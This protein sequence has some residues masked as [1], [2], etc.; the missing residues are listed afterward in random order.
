MT[1]T[2]GSAL[3]EGVRRVNAAPLVVAGTFLVTLLIALPLAIA[4]GSM[5]EAHLGASLAA[6]AAAA[7]TN[8][9]WWQEFSSQAVGLATTFVPSIIGA[10]AVLDN[11]SNFVDRVPL[12]TTV[13]GAVAAWLVIWSF[14]SGGVLDRLARA[15]KTRT[16]GFFAAC[17]THFWRFLRLGA[18]AWVVYLAVFE[19]VHGWIFTSAL[20]ALTRETTVERT[21]FLFRLAG[22][23]LFGV[24]LVG[25]NIIFDYARIRIVVEDR[26]SAIGALAAGAR[27]AARHARGVAGLYALNGLAFL[28]L[29]L[30]YALLAPGAPGAGW[31]MWVTFAIGQAY[32]LGRHYLKLLFYASETAFFQHA[33]AHAAYTA[34]P[35]VVWPD[36]PA[37]EAIGQAVPKAEI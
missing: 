18:V 2:A 12:A 13:A 7:S 1:A 29:V 8:Y 14:V 16:P 4:L 35:T 11:L 26:R 10:G 9:D 17:G 23:G 24:L 25:C 19:Y 36:S 30:A 22:Y 6:D 37:A 28:G 15:R 3:R 33:L 31:S 20:G 32:I 34:S 27:F 21:A 5:I